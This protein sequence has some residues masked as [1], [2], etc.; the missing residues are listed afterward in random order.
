MY[1]PCNIYK[2]TLY[3]TLKNDFNNLWKMGTYLKNTKSTAALSFLP[4]VCNK[5]ETTWKLLATSEVQGQH[6]T[7]SKNISI[8][9]YMYAHT[10]KL[11][12]TIQ[13]KQSLGDI[14]F[15]FLNVAK[16]NKKTKQNQINQTKTQ[17]ANVLFFLFYMYWWCNKLFVI[18]NQLDNK[19]FDVFTA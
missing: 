17:S 6:T 3:M 1:K 2:Y 4:P 10:F 13:H 16:L 14:F 19:Q 7:E 11:S 12:V 9:W 15:P 18:W 5:E 8:Q